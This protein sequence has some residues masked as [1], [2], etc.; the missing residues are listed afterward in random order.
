[1]RFSKRKAFTLTELLVVVIVVG[2][3][4]AVAVPKFTRVLET[5]RTTEAENILAA[6]RTEQEK[7]CSLGQ[8]Y[9]GDF[10][11]I[12]TVAYAKTSGVA[13]AKTANYTYTM[14]QT[15]VNAVRPGKDYVIRM[16]SYKS[17]QMCC[18]GVDCA[19]LNKSYPLC[20]EIVVQKDEC[21]ADICEIR[22]NSCECEKYAQQNGCECAPSAETCC[23]AGEVY[24][25][26]VC[27]S[28]CEAYQNTSSC[29]TAEEIAQGKEY[30][31]NPDITDK[32]GSSKCFC[33]TGERVVSGYNGGASHCC[34]TNTD[35]YKNGRCMT[36]CEAEPNTEN[37]CED[38]QEWNGSECEDICV[39]L[40]GLV[41][42]SN[43]PLQDT[44]PGGDNINAFSCPGNLEEKLVCTDAT[45]TTDRVNAKAWTNVSINPDLP[46]GPVSVDKQN[47]FLAWNDPFA[48]FANPDTWVAQEV[49]I[50]CSDCKMFS[51]ICSAGQ[52]ECG[53]TKTCYSS[54]EK[55][56]KAC[57]SGGGG[58][59]TETSSGCI[60]CEWP[61]TC[62]KQASKSCC[63]E[64]GC[65]SDKPHWNGVTCIRCPSDKPYWNGK[66][67]VSC[68]GGQTWDSSSKQCVCPS[69]KPYWNGEECISCPSGTTWD[70]SKKEC[71]S[72][73]QDPF[74]D[75]GSGNCVC[76]ASHPYEY[77]NA[78]YTCPEGYTWI[79]NRKCE[80]KSYKSIVVT[81]CPK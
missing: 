72:T 54:W 1:M 2:V 74:V 40:L 63:L 70:E 41:E 6:V 46:E 71:V 57:C 78:C 31:S 35:V 23:Q 64:C 42:T 17:G 60:S 29:C 18:E 59:N 81:C 34:P 80:R 28:P 47:A 25:N 56:A 10:A 43:A 68:K 61:R 12:P 9:T 19:G 37:C 51:D 21:A 48:S 38:G 39:E 24:I 58:W 75:D 44:C 69:D 5:R 53:A 11:K 30:N 49:T 55:C 65:P 67:C 32:A 62:V 66:E 22:P 4:A 26:G 20:S 52:W 50:N 13:E 27:M 73:C 45:T 79:G 36:M 14:T 33:P 8:N 16:P 3:L 15:G 7:R 76:R 77:N